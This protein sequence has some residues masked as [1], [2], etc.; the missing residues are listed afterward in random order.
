MQK[1]I[2]IGALLCCA[3][4]DADTIHLKSGRQIE[5]CVIVQ[6]NE[7]DVV[8]TLGYGTVTIPAA[9]IKSIEPKLVDFIDADKPPRV[10]REVTI[11]TAVAKQPWA[12]NFRQIPAT[13][14]DK[15]VLA[16]V[17]YFSYQCGNG[18]ELNIYGDPDQPACIEMGI[19][20]DALKDAEAK[21][22]C[23]QFIASVLGDKNDAAI[24]KSLNRTKDNHTRKN[25]TFEVT[26]TSAEDSYG[27]W[28]I[29]VY[30]KT[31]LDSVRATPAEIK[32]ITVAKDESN[33]KPEQPAQRNVAPPKPPERNYDEPYW[34]PVEIKKSQPNTPS[35]NRGSGTGRVYVKGYYRK[36]GTYVRSHT[37][38]RPRR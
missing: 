12:T 31:R 18:Y 14:V 35:V 5:N 32:D 15:G 11:V 19:V 16:H 10:P 8:F 7:T 28:W 30:D 37:R 23:I 1:S 25:L 38:S 4:A 20:A 17:P 36:D 13:V 9:E 24:V 22:N 33:E 3:V 34:S 26:P 2:L 29:S 27:G 21:S 6:K